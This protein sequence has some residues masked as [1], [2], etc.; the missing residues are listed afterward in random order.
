[1][2]YTT[3]SGLCRKWGNKHFPVSQSA[4]I[5]KMEAQQTNRGEWHLMYSKPAAMPEAFD[6]CCIRLVNNIAL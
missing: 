6:D 5:Q 2:L 1:M 3:R 4:Y